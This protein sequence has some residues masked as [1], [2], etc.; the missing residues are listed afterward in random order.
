ML[1]KHEI[2]MLQSNKASILALNKEANRLLHARN[3]LV[4]VF[5]GDIHHNTQELYI[6][7]T[8]EDKIEIKDWCLLF[9]D[10]GHLMSDI[11]RQYLGEKAEH[12]LN[13][14]LRK[15][16]ASTDESLGL[17][18]VSEGFIK[19]F[20]EK[21][22]AGDKIENIMVEYIQTGTGWL[23]DNDEMLFFNNREVPK[24]DIN[25]TITIKPVKDTFSK[26]D[27]K[28]AYCDGWYAIHNKVLKS[29]I[30]DITFEEWFNQ[31][32]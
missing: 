12:Y 22:N 27:L 30:E 5:H 4:T 2:V 14:G 29:D 28:K 31:N 32:F 25:N 24:V 18:K 7:G 20:I 13:S 1:K 9:D 6:L 11:P 17:P 16:I 15:V 3:Y 26:N 19:K 23:N 8:K 21:Y 10:L